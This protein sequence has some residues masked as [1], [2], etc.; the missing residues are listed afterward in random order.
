MRTIGFCIYIETKELTI[1]TLWK[2]LYIICVYHS[3]MYELKLRHKILGSQD[4][5]GVFSRHG[6]AF[7]KSFIPDHEKCNHT[8]FESNVYKEI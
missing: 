5:A 4:N 3:T 7:V 2:V 6:M 8:K 1:E